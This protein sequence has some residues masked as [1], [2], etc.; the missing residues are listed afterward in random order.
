MYNLHWHSHFVMY[1]QKI[2]NMNLLQAYITISVIL[3]YYMRTFIFSF[4][5]LTKKNLRL[6]NYVA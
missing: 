5:I 3:S 2:T 1:P 4:K 6:K